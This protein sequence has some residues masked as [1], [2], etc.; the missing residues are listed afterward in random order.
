MP[1]WLYRNL[2]INSVFYTGDEAGIMCSISPKDSKLPVIISLTHLK[3]PY[4][5]QLEKE[6]RALKNVSGSSVSKAACEP[7][8]RYSGLVA[9]KGNR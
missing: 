7:P 2:Q 1:A 4:R 5:H 3:I 8:N 9:H 6:I